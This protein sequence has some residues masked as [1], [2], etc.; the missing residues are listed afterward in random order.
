VATIYAKEGNTTMKQL[1][2]YLLLLAVLSFCAVGYGQFSSN[3]QGMVEDPTGAAVPNATVSLRNL[4]TGVTVTTTT[5]QAGF[6]RFNSLAPGR[7]EVTG[8]ASGFQPC[9][10]EVILQTAQTKDVLLP[11]TISG[12]A[13]QVTVTAKAPAIDIADSRLQQTLTDEVMHDLPMK[14]RNFMGLT[15]LAPGVTGMGGYISGLSDVAD[16]FGNE[17]SVDASANGRG[18]EANLYTLDGMSLNSNIMPGVV[19]LAPNPDSIQE[20]AVQTNT[21]STEQGRESSIV[22]AMTT[23][24]GTNDFH[25]TASWFYT[26]QH[27]SARSVFTSKYEPFHKNDMSGGIG[28]PIRKERTFFFA[29]IEPLRSSASTS[30]Q[31]R[32]FESV[33]FVNWAKEFFP[34]ALGTQLLSE[35]PATN[36]VITGVARTAQNVF[37]SSCGTPATSGIP[38]DLPMVYTGTYK[39]SPFRNGLQYSGRVDHNFNHNRDRIYGNFYQTGVDTERPSIRPSSRRISMLTSRTFQVNQTHTFSGNFLNEASFALHRVYGGSKGVTNLHVPA[40]TITA[41]NTGLGSGAPLIYYQHNYDWRDVVSLVRGSHTIKI[42]LEVWHGDDDARFAAS[43]SKPAFRFN[44][45][46]DLVRGDVYSES[47]VA[48]DPK[49]GK[50]TVGDYKYLSTTEGAFIQDRKSVV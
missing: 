3:I 49:T 19:N 16:N 9:K 1:R 48:F 32:T 36:V 29:S 13:D 2:W 18:P 34:D 26:D 11:L 35:Y 41:Q 38:C 33:E 39:P 21:F 27:L 47:G 5:S 15:A 44:N 37:G 12:R 17:K 43:R 8:K 40:I 14:G 20:I 10:V 42:G 25:G 23:K 24:S 45:L 7:Y 50:A 28:G 4:E 6:Y 31:V 46:L 30:S 22:A